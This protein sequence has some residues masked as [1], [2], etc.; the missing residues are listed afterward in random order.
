MSDYLLTHGTRETPQSEPMRADQVE[1]S[2]GG[3]VFE[4]DK[5]GRLQR[6]LILGSEGPTFYSTERKLTTE[7][8]RKYI[9]REDHGVYTVCPLYE[10]GSEGY[11]AD[12]GYSAFGVIVK[13]SM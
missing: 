11:R 13:E 6:W 2:A 7:N 1:N 4:L 8:A 9:V 12:A 3:W 5:W 10:L